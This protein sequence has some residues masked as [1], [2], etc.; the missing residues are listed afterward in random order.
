[1]L[2][3]KWNET[4]KLNLFQPEVA[5]PDNDHQNTEE[6]HYELVR[7]N[8]DAVR[9]PFG[10]CFKPSKISC[11]SQM[12]ICL[13]CASFCST[14]DNLPEYEE[15]IKHVTEQIKIGER[16]GREEWVYKNKEYLENLQKKKDRILQEG[17]VH[18]TGKLR[19]E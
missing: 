1:M 2:Y 4:E 11:K 3:Q 14:K 19:E 10:V 9:V 8:L 5:S 15:E 16:L 13:D 17:L 7:K 18:K 12:N 6:I